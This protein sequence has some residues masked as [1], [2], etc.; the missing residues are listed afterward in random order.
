MYQYT[1]LAN[2]NL[3]LKVT[4]ITKSLNPFTVSYYETKSIILIL[5]LL[6]KI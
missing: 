4:K 6:C 3:K 5:N 2:P 1:S